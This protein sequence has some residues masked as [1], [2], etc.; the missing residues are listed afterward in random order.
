MRNGCGDHRGASGAIDGFSA[1][2]ELTG[3]TDAQIAAS[4][5]IL[6]RDPEVIADLRYQ[7]SAL[8]V[9]RYDL[10]HDIQVIESALAALRE[11]SGNAS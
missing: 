2:C 10:E 6:L 9:V 7:I 5:Q 4:A 8:S 1:D 3:V 11:A